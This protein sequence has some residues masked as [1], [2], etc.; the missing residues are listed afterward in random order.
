MEGSRIKEN[1]L[2]NA[3][4]ANNRREIK[5]TTR[6]NKIFS[7]FKEQQLVYSLE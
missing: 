1:I 7:S 6:P 2:I 3:A 5:N 4:Q